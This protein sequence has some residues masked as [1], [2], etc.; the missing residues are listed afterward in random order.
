LTEAN[1]PINLANV[2]AVTTATQI[3]LTWSPGPSNGGTP[4]LDYTVSYD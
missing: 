4:I 2:P 3:G 1:A